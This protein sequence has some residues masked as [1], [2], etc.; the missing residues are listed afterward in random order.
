MAFVNASLA[1]LYGLDPAKYGADLVQ[2]TLD[3][4]HGG[5]SSGFGGGSIAFAHG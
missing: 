1:P 4:A 5:S 3:A 2:V